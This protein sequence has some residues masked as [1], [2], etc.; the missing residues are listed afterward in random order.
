M[1][2][3]TQ[4]LMDESRSTS[5]TTLAPSFSD[6][7]AGVDIRV[8]AAHRYAREDGTSRWADEDSAI[9]DLQ[10]TSTQPLTDSIYDF[11]IEYG[12]RYHALRAGNY[13]LP[14]D[15]QEMER[16]DFVH[17]IIFRVLG[18]R[19]CLA[20]IDEKKIERVLDMGTGTGIWALEFA[21][22]F[23]NA[24]VLGNDLSP[25][26][27]CWVPPNVKFVIDDIESPWSYRNPFD[28]IFGRYL[29]TAIQD[30][31]SLVR[32]T[33]ENVSA[34]GWVELQDFDLTVYCDDW[35][36]PEDQPIYQW[37]QLLIDGARMMG[38]EPS[39][40]VGLRGWMEAAGFQEV[41]HRQFKVPIGG[42]SDDTDLRVIGLMF[43]SQ[44]IDGLEAFS[45][46]LLCNVHGW[47]E[48]RVRTVLARVRRDF[49]S[50]MKLYMHYHVVY[51]R[52]PE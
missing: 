51:G 25:I 47:D 18:H 28:L 44:T 23:P 45:L 48:E 32:S 2:A 50:G 26:Q 30:W 46:R 13:V 21:D 6:T 42:W 9:D 24:Q 52:K 5:T 1:A 31:P 12:R 3:V 8:D 16:L 11:P 7:A 38:R 4:R 39:P 37:A 36:R 19:L 17:E 10:S 20:P 33:F 15:Q 35:D 34:G 43:L 49:L 22:R 27:Q 14:N 29:A 40:G 41:T